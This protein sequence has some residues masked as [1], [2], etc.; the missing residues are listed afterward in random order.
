[1]LPK[2][3]SGSICPQLV[4]CGRKNC[5]CARGELHGPYFYRFW[6]ED[7]R[8][9]KTYVKQADAKKLLAAQAA[10]RRRQSEFHTSLELWRRLQDVLRGME[11]Q[12]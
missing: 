9:R 7:G 5:R 10:E 11:T 3:E 6:R 4:R 2:I 8:L 1:M 12:G